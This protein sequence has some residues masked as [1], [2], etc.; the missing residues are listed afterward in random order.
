MSLPSILRRSVI[1]GGGLLLAAT[2]SAQTGQAIVTGIVSDESGG[3]LPGLTVTATHRATS[4]SYTGLTNEAGNY[5]ITGLP[6]GAYVVAARMAG[7]KGVQSTVELSAAQTARVDFR[8]PLGN[9]EENVEIVAT[10]AVLQTENAVVGTRLERAQIERLPLQGRTLS[11][12]TLY[13]PGATTPNPTSF[14]GLRGG[15]RPFVN[16]QREQ[17]NNFTLDG[18]DTNE[19]INNTI[20][21]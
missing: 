20:A 21:Y 11:T 17:S 7:F 12:A 15:G 6:I 5:V 19:A 4:I 1:V 16:G 14:T 2:A 8:L 10:G 3:A 18:V 9:V 13:T